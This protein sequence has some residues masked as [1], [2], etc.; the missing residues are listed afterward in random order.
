MNII[1]ACDETYIPILYVSIKTLIKNNADALINIYIVGDHVTAESKKLIN[2]LCTSL[3]NIIWMPFMNIE[4]E[5]GSKV[6][7]DRGSYAQFARI[8]IGR[9]LPKNIKKILYLDCDTMIKASI[10]QLWETDLKQY[11]FAACLDAFSP[12]YSKNLGLNKDAD[13]INSGVLLI[14]MDRWRSQDYERKAIKILRTRKGKIQQADQ[15][16]LDILCQ[17]DLLILNPMF[18][19]INGYFEFSYPEWLKYRRPNKNY[20]LVYTQSVIETAS[21]TPIIIH[22]TSSFLGNRPWIDESQHPFKTEWLDEVGSYK[23][24]LRTSSKSIFLK[25]LFYFLPRSISIIIFGILQAYIRPIFS[26]L[27][28]S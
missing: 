27:G 22:F 9:M 10:I 2:S 25:N 15:G 5:I 4:E 14:N 3:N 26:K 16:L 1:Y 23:R 7:L 17:N 11:S 8:F 20:R 19:C 13:L 6:K 24:F 12:L 18:N 21:K 28:D